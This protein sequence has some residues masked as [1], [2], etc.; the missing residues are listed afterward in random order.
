VCGTDAVFQRK[1]KQLL[2]GAAT[3]F[4]PLLLLLL[5]LLL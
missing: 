4:L 3:A 5:L 1:R 2:P